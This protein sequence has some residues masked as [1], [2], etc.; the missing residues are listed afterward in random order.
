MTLRT[1]LTAK[2]LCL[3]LS[4]GVLVPLAYGL[5]SATP[6]TNATTPPSPEQAAES[7]PPAPPAEQ[8][9][10]MPATAD[11]IDYQVMLEGATVINGSLTFEQ[12]VALMRKHHGQELDTRLGQI[13]LITA[14]LAYLRQSQP[15]NWRAPM[16]ALL[17][18]AFPE[19]AA[20]LLQLPNNHLE[21]PP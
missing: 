21:N 5:T 8:P 15:E 14:L 4:L 12:V 1:P 20:E 2:S 10:Q 16:Q 7:A 17:E 19:I 6:T 3:S 13:D 11:T 9:V 18:A